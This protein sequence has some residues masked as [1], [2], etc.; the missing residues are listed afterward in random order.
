MGFDQ[1]RGGRSLGLRP[2][3]WGSSGGFRA[4]CRLGY[5]VLSVVFSLVSMVRAR[6]R[7]SRFAEAY[8]QQYLIK[9]PGGYCPIHATGVTC[10][11]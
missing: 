5:P 2:L 7:I 10:R 11:A 1:A 8:H 6:A 3:V 9:N 4:G